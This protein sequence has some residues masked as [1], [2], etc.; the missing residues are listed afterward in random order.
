MGTVASATVPVWESKLARKPDKARN[1]DS[2]VTLISGFVYPTTNLLSD[3]SVFHP[4]SVYPFVLLRV[5][6]LIALRFEFLTAF[7]DTANAVSTGQNPRR[8]PARSNGHYPF[9]PICVVST[10]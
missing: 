1:P 7:H 8:L 3:L 9:P 5:A 6:L 10:K 4:T 2:W